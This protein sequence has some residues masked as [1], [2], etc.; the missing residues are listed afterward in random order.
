MVAIATGLSP[1]ANA[2]RMRSYFAYVFQMARS[3][4]L[5]KSASFVSPQ[6]RSLLS[7]S[8]VSSPDHSAEVCPDQNSRPRSE[9]WIAEN[10]ELEVIVEEEMSG[11][12]LRV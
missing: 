12:Q 7:E 2:R 9:E 5:P 10:D 11:T 3:R 1:S 4:P 8:R 6:F